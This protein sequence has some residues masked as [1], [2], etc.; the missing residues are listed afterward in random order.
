MAQIRVS[1]D[2]D[3]ALQRLRET[4]PE[5]GVEVEITPKIEPERVQNVRDKIKSV[6]SQNVSFSG[7]T[8]GFDNFAGKVFSNLA[9]IKAGFDMAFGAISNISGMIEGFEQFSSQLQEL[10][11]GLKDIEQSGG[12]LERLRTATKGLV[13]DKDLI[14]YA[15]KAKALGMSMKMIEVGATASAVAVSKGLSSSFE[16]AGHAY[17]EFVGG[18]GDEDQFKKIF[19]QVDQGLTDTEAG[20]KAAREMA[21]EAFGEGRLDAIRLFTSTIENLQLELGRVGADIIANTGLVDDF[22]S[23]IRAM[24]DFLKSDGF[25]DALSGTSDLIKGISKALTDL[26]EFAKPAVEALSDALFG[27][28]LLEQEGVKIT[29]NGQNTIRSNYAGK[30]IGPDG[31]QYSS[32]EEWLARNKNKLTGVDTGERDATALANATGQKRPGSKAGQKQGPDGSKSAPFQVKVINAEV[33]NFTSKLKTLF[34]N[35]GARLMKLVEDPGFYPFGVETSKAENIRTGQ[36]IKLEEERKN[37]QNQLTYQ[38]ERARNQLKLIEKEKEKFKGTA[39]GYEFQDYGQRDRAYAEKLSRSVFKSERNKSKSILFAVEQIEKLYEELERIQKQADKAKEEL[40]RLNNNKKMLDESVVAAKK[41]DFV[42]QKKNEEQKIRSRKSY[43]DLKEAQEREEKLIASSIRADIESSRDKLKDF[44]P[45]KN[46]QK[47][48]LEELEKFTKN[49]RQ[50]AGNSLEQVTIYV[51]GSLEKAKKALANKEM[52][53]GQY[54]R[55]VEQLRKYSDDVSFIVRESVLEFGQKATVIQKEIIEKYKKLRNEIFESLGEEFESLQAEFARMDLTGYDLKEAVANFEKQTLR[56]EFEK[57]KKQIAEDLLSKGAEDSEIANAIQKLDETL[58]LK[59][60][61]ID[62]ELQKS[63]ID[64]R[65]KADDLKRSLLPLSATNPEADNFGYSYLGLGQIQNK[66][67]DKFKGAASMMSELGMSTE[68]LS[69]EGMKTFAKDQ[70]GISSDEFDQMVGTMQNF[71]SQVDQMTTG[72][73][74]TLQDT[75]V[76]GWTDFW[77]NLAAGVKK[78]DILKSMGKLLGG[79]LQQMGQMMLTLGMSATILAPLAPLLGIAPPVASFS[80]AGPGLIAAGLLLTAGGAALG[81]AMSRGGSGGKGGGGSTTRNTRQSSL[82]SS[83]P[84]ANQTV[85]I[86]VNATGLSSAAD[87][88]NM[89]Y[90]ATQRAGINRP[91]LSRV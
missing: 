78:S 76:T 36:L 77:G 34:E 41:N 57:R 8:A 30:Y 26:K 88:G 2:M 66:T 62:K 12:S 70:F 28:G 9:N 58:L 56:K 67:L 90:E 68:G 31:K 15:T 33:F 60:K 32:R 27:S 13:S 24:A 19:G 73:M 87:I 18:L 43:Q 40:D 69:I 83:S 46:K 17:A 52:T 74:S 47:S 49:Y 29:I 85:Q 39:F 71:K 4:F 21:K 89:V 72:I 14:A 44:S 55:Y 10:D 25:K 64:L 65:K 59:L 61:I 50:L 54:D 81:G 7:L 91:S 3:E 37:Q 79:M 38:E 45:E 20:F 16:T 35:L 53:Q 48:E 6:L 80:A 23:S 5:E 1:L 63:D 75:F 82:L 11:K 22:A 86:I 51:N 84:S 42:R